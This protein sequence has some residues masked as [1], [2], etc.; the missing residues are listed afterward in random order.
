MGSF[1]CVEAY[2]PAQ[3]LVSMGL[4]FWQPSTT[5]LSSPKLVATPAGRAALAQHQE[6]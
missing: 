3:K 4:A 5:G 2:K 6:K 1:S